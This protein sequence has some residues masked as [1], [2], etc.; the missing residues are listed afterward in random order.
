MA[1]LVTVVLALII[2]VVILKRSDSMVLGILVVEVTALMIISLTKN[3]LKIPS[4][5]NF[6]SLTLDIRVVAMFVIFSL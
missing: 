1:M 6:L 2:M 4:T 5:L 3:R